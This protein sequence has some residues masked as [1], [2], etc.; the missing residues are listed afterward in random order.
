M[1]IVSQQSD[2]GTG[3][4]MPPDPVTNVGPDPGTAVTFRSAR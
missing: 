3:D 4:G 2:D 1:V